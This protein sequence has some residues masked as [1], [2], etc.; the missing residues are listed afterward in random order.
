MQPLAGVVVARGELAGVRDPGQLAARYDESGRR[1]MHL[2]RA[3]DGFDVFARSL[4]IGAETMVMRF[5]PDRPLHDRYQVDHDFLAPETGREVVTIGRTVNAFFRWEFNSLRD[6][7]PGRR[8]PPDRLRQRLP[9]RHP[10]LL[11]YYFPW[12]IKALVRWCV[13]CSVTGRRMHVAMAPEPWFEI[14]DADAPLRGEARGLPRPRRRLL[15]GRAPTRS[16]ATATSPMSTRRWPATST[17]RVR[18]AAGPDR[19]ARVPAARA[20]AA[21]SRTTAACSPPGCATS[22]R[23]AAA[24]PARRRAAARSARAPRRRRG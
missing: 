9:R 22:A 3:V 13:Y 21:S 15:R 11:H 7:D 17:A 14:G 16:S 4:S 1:L 10:D 23:R 8:G 12:A 18:R 2:Q 19:H 24:A 5:E 6:A 20:R